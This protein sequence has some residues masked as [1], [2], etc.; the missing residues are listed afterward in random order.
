[1]TIKVNSFK[2]YAE[3]TNQF[4]V[5][6]DE[7]A[8]DYVWLGLA[9]EAA[10]LLGKYKKVLRGDKTFEEQLPDLKA[11]EGDSVWY[12]AQYVLKYNISIDLLE[13]YDEQLS[14]SAS[15]S[16]IMELFEDLMYIISCLP[17]I[18]KDKQN[19]TLTVV[20]LK[21]EFANIQ[22]R[23]SFCKA[24]YF[25]LKELARRFYSNLN[26]IMNDNLNKLSD[27]KER[28]VIKGSGDLR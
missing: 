26:E 22:Y 1:M 17:K 9:N 18:G 14:Y 21:E 24:I 13:V 8:L 5:F 23:T 4:A 7:V 28:G 11:E 27:R 12:F 10:E 2:E 25:I 16:T 6:P 19:D 15:K 20:D 3:A